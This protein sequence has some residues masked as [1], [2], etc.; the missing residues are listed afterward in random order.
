[1]TSSLTFSNSLCWFAISLF[2]E[3]SYWSALATTPASISAQAGAKE[4]INFI[5]IFFLLFSNHKTT[6]SKKHR[7]LTFSMQSYFNPTKRNMKK[8]IG[9]P[10]VGRPGTV[11]SLV[12]GRTGA[13]I[14]S[15]AGGEGR[16][17]N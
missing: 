15:G 2:V 11:V 5:E 3:A 8:K 14:G 1:L 16:S 12:S 13:G 9:L 7:K 4:A 6:T 17:G 10:C